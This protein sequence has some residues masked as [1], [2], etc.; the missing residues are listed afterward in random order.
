M[1][2]Y[3]KALKV[4]IFEKNINNVIEKR[5]IS[6]SYLKKEKIYRKW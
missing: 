1:S 6:G 5:S 4:Q 3:L 2:R